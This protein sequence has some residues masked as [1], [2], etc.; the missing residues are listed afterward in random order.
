MLGC[1]E[2]KGRR[3]IQK[4]SRF[5]DALITEASKNDINMEEMFFETIYEEE[6]EI[7]VQ[8][9]P[10]AIDWT[11]NAVWSMDK[12]KLIEFNYRD[13]CNN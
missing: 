5:F 10:F 2:S 8:Y 7:G 6:N 1:N 3:N 9:Y 11:L 13:N 12:K 4:I